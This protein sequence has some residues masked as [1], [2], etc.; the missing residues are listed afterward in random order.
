MVVRWHGMLNISGSEHANDP[1]SAVT[2]GI[3]TPMAKL[4]HDAYVRLRSKPTGR[5][6]VHPDLRARLVEDADEIGTSL[7][8]VVVRILAVHYG[9]THAMAK[10]RRKS[11]TPDAPV[12]K[13][14]IPIDVWRALGFAAKASDREENDV[15]REVL[16]SHYDLKVGDNGDSAAA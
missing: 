6:L 15:I 14:R 9:L 5:W 7:T 8:D 11:A 10:G 4:Y 2:S 13:L 3:L 1:A 16:C 12:L